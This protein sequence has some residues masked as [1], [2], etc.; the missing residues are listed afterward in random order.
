M[1]SKVTG[2]D[3][4]STVFSSIVLPCVSSII[5]ITIIIIIIIMIIVLAKLADQLCLHAMPK[6]ERPVGIFI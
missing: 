1:K 3:P 6:P 4:I 5:I 2:C